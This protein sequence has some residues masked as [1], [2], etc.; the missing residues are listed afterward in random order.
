MA[1]KPNLKSGTAKKPVIMA[2]IAPFSEN[3]AQKIDK[4]IVG[5]NVAAIPDQPNIA[6]QK[7]VL[8]GEVTAIV[9]AI[10]KASSAKMRVMTLE[11]FVICL[12]VL[13]GLKI[14]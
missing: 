11:I 8:F 6:N 5:Q 4:I 1:V 9:I 2:A 10:A 7:I 12:S 3:L 13:F 14:C